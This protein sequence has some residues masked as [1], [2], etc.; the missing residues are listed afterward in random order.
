[1]AQEWICDPILD[2]T[3]DASKNILLQSSGPASRS[4]AFL[5]DAD[6]RPETAAA[7]SLFNVKMRLIL[8]KVKG[9]RITGDA[10][11]A[12]LDK[13]AQEPILLMYF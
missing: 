5:L 12:P 2:L 9:K 6:L 10:A 4:D 8:G 11:S 13:S 3:G 7:I 1:M